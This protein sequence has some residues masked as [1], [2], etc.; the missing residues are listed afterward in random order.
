VT[1]GWRYSPSKTTPANLRR[2][3]AEMDGATVDKLHAYTDL[4]RPIVARAVRGSVRSRRR[5]PVLAGDDPYW[6]ETEGG[7]A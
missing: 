7:D 6:Y 3:I 5:L 1:S 2:E 4:L